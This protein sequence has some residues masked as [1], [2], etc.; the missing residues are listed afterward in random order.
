MTGFDGLGKPQGNK[1]SQALVE[2]AL[3]GRTY[4]IALRRAGQALGP[5]GGVYET[6]LGT[7][8]ASGKA[9]VDS[10]L[11]LGKGLMWL[12]TAG[13]ADLSWMPNSLTDMLP[14]DMATRLDA[15][16]LLTLNAAYLKDAG[17]PYSQQSAMCK[18]FAAETATFAAHQ[19]VQIHGGYGYTKEYGV[20]RHYRDARITEIYEGTSEVQRIVISANLFR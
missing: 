4:D 1:Y 9:I 2:D 20:E 15:A 10:T 13:Q 14:T 17:K 18:V 12:G 7:L 19:G 5:G 3:D 16:R 8:G 6:A 11:G